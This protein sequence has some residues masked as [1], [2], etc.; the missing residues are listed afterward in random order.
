VV[1]PPLALVLLSVLCIFLLVPFR[2][3]GGELNLRSELDESRTLRV[4]TAVYEQ[5]Y[6]CFLSLSRGGRGPA[7]VQAGLKSAV[8]TA[9]PVRRTGL[10]RLLFR[11]LR[12]QP[13]SRLFGEATGLSL[14]GSLKGG[15][16]TGLLL[17]PFP[18]RLG[19]FCFAVPGQ[20][21]KSGCLARWDRGA[22]GRLLHLGARADWIFPAWTLNLLTAA[23]GGR[24]APPGCLA[25]LAA[26]CSSGGAE[27]ALA[28]G[29]CST[30][31]LTPDGRG[32]QPRVQAG[33]RGR[34]GGEGRL[35][36]RGLAQ[37]LLLPPACAY[38]AALSR[39]ERGELSARLLSPAS[40]GGRWRLE[41]GIASQKGSRRAEAELARESARHTL[42]A[43]WV[44][45]REDSLKLKISGRR[46]GLQWRA[47]LETRLTSAPGLRAGGAVELA[48][49]DGRFY[50]RLSC[51]EWLDPAEL[52]R[53]GF[54]ALMRQASFTLGWETR[55]GLPAR[56]PGGRKLETAEM[57]AAA[58]LFDPSGLDVPGD[59][60]Q[61]AGRSQG[62]GVGQRLPQA[63]AG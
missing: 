41:G 37:L 40:A 17:E 22:G 26:S 16:R 1:K 8:L 29:V 4:Q 49:E 7:A 39:E 14:N 48:W 30:A 58:Q 45:D 23:S 28:T 31:F 50:A 32:G 13:G 24:R 5:R 61:A 44:R 57:D 12:Y 3:E 36:V 53:A 9:G 62:R 56:R 42:A 15:R 46:G 63:G 21:A 59:Q 6:C 55:A 38:G 11:P 51:R 43:G 10:L 35:Q 47:A 19:L 52:V 34:L 25:Q 60:A 18:G 54:P 27:L 2:L 33:V 20:A